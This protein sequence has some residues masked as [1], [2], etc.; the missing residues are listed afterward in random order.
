MPDLRQA[1][2]DFVATSNSGKYA[3][4]E[5]L[6]SKFPELKGYDIQV[7]K[8]FVATSNSGK[9]KTENEL[10]SKFP[11]F[12]LGGAIAPK[13]KDS[14]A[15]I[16]QQEPQAGTTVSPSADGSSV[17]PPISNKKFSLTTQDLNNINKKQPTDMS[18]NPLLPNQKEP[19]KILEKIYKENKALEIERKKYGDIFDNQLNIKPRVDESQYLK[20]RLSSIDTELINKTESF[21]VPKL[22]YQFGDLGFKFEEARAGRDYVKAIAPNG[23]T[24]EISLDNWQDETSKSESEVLKKF[25]KD[26]TPAKGLFVLEKTMRE[27]DKKFNSEKQVDDSVKIISNQVTALNAK[28]KQFLIKKS[29]FEKEIA[30]LS[31]NTNQEKLNELEQQRLSLNEEIKSILQEE[32]TIKQ[33]SKILDAAVGK[34]SIAKS[35]QGSWG[36]A[37]WNSINE[38]FSSISAGTSSL[39]TDIATEIAPA[40]F[41][42]SPKD[43]KNAS[44]DVAKKI[45]VKGPSENQTVEQWKKTLTEDQLDDWEDGIDD[46]IKKDIKSRTLPYIRIGNREILGDAATTKEFSD[47]KQQGFWGGAILGV[48]KSL[49]AMIGGAGPAGWAQRTAQ[50]YTQIADGLAVEMEN[51]P[52]FANIT[53]NEKLA[54]TLPIGITSAVLEAYGL[55]NIMASKGVITSLTMSALGR[56]G[57]GV[58]AKTFRE[59]VENEIKSKLGRGLLI[60]TAAG[61]AE[62]ETGAAQEVTETGFKV[63]YDEIKGKDMF[64]TPD[65]ISDFIR[66]VAVAGAQEAVG[67]F[68][69]GVP[70]GISAAYSKKGFLKMDNL[71]FETFANM[72]NDTKLQSAYIA[73]LK[74]KITQGI[75]TEKEAKERLNNYRNSVGL[76]RRLPDGLTTEQQKEAMNLL[77]EKRD[78]DN[79][80]EGKDPALVVKAK[81]RITEINNELTNLSEK[82]SAEYIIDDK[83][84]TK[85]EFLNELKDKTQEELK[86]MKIVVNN[87]QETMNSINEK[88]KTNAIQ[89]QTADESVLRTEQ[90]ELGLQEVGEGNAQGEV[91]TEQGT[92][93]VTPSETI[94]T[95]QEVVG[96]PDEVSQPIELSVTPEAPVTTTQGIP[97][98]VSQP[99]ELSVTPEV[100]PEQ[101]SEEVNSKILELENQRDAEIEALKAKRQYDE[102]NIKPIREKYEALILDE[103]AK[104]Q[105]PTETTTETAPT[106]KSEQDIANEIN[107]KASEAEVKLRIDVD[108]ESPKLEYDG[109]N[110]SIKKEIERYDRLTRK[111][112]EDG[113]FSN[114]YATGFIVKLIEAGLGKNTRKTANALRKAG[115][116]HTYS[117]EMASGNNFTT[118]INDSSEL[119]AGTYHIL[120]NSEKIEATKIFTKLAKELGIDV[121]SLE[122]EANRPVEKIGVEAKAEVAPAETTEETAPAAET[123]AELDKINSDIEASKERLKKAWD[124]YK[125]MGIA[126]DPKNNL[127]R[128]KEL[129]NS[130]IEYAYNNI[131]LG[132]YNASKFIKDLAEQGFEITKDGAK[133]IIDKATQKIA[134]EE[135]KA[136]IKDLKGQVVDVFKAGIQA[137]KIAET[138]AKEKA[139]DIKIKAKELAKYLDNLKGKGKIT[140]TQAVVIIKRFSEVNVLSEKSVNR[141]IDYATKVLNDA[142]YN[143]KLNEARKTLSSLKKL[144]K[145]AEKNADLR[146]VASQ[147]VKIDPSMVENIDEYNNIAKELKTALDGSKIRRTN[148]N[149]ADTVNIDDV[150]TYVDEIL[151][152]QEIKSRAEKIAELQ[153]LLDVDASQFSAEEIDN[154]FDIYAEEKE[155]DTKKYDSKIVRAALNKAFDIYST[156]IN[157]ML[158]TGVDPFTGE[159]VEF[160]DDQKKIIREF[161]GIDLDTIEDNKEALRIIDSLINFIQNKSTAGMLKPI[162]DY[163]AIVGGNELRRQKIEGK[164]IRK[165]WSPSFGKMLAEQ[166]TSLNLLFEKEFKGFNVAS[167]VRKMMGITDLVNGKSIGQSEANRIVKK[168]VEQF[169]NKTANGEAFNSAYNDIERG[170]FAHVYRNV[171]GTDK[172]RKAVFDK[173]KQEVLDAIDFLE[174]NGNKEEKQLAELYKKAYDKILDKSENIDDVRQKTDAN[175]VDG[176]NYWVNQWAGK[177]DALSDLALNFY[178]KILNRDLGYT[179]DRFKRLQGE[180]KEVDL[181]NDESAF[182][183]NTDGVLYN[184]KSGSLMDKQENRKPPKGMFIDL[185][186]D[187]KNSNSM[188]DAMIDLN[189]A[190]SI[191]KVQSFLNSDNFKKIFKDDADLFKKRISSY[192]R[193]S[194]RKSPYIGSELSGLIQKLDKIATIGVTQALASPTQPFKQTI[195][196][197]ASTLINAGTLGMG[198]AFNP[199]YNNWL[200]KLGYAVS[201]RGMQSSAEIESINRLLEKAANTKKEKVGKFIREANEKMLK[202]TLVKPDVW[203]AR[204]SFKAYYEQYL[205]KEGLYDDV[206]KKQRFGVTEID[207]DIHDPNDD[208]ADYAQ[209]M[210]DRQQNISDHD[211]AGDL[212]TDKNSVTKAFIK[213][214]MAFSSFRMNQGSRLGADLTTLEYWNTST[215]EDKVIALRSIAGYTAEQAVF[216]GLQIT[217]GMMFYFAAKSLMGRGEDDDEDKK[218]KN[219]LIKNSSTGAI[220]DTFSPLPLLDP[221]IQNLAAASVDTFEDIVNIPEEDKIKLF[222]ANKQEAIKAL[223]VY[224]I[225]PERAGQMFDLIK[226]AYGKKYTD[227]YGKQKEISEEDADALKVLIGPYLAASVTGVLAPDVSSLVRK[228]IKISKKGDTNA[229]EER[230][231]KEA[232]QAEQALEDKQEVSLLKEMMDKETNSEKKMIIKKK[233]N[234]LIYETDESKEARKEANKVEKELKEKLLEGY[235]NQSEMKR[236]DPVKWEKNFGEKSDWYKNHKN[237][238]EID[239]QLK[240]EEQK[241]LD[242]EYNYTPKK[243]FGSKTFGTKSSKSK[244]FGSKT[245]GAK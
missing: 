157:Q 204:A 217:F 36:G 197:A 220:T 178:N 33:K 78:L 116:F 153:N 13:K 5:T 46:Y 187:S 243:E 223:G 29:Q 57:T 21:V 139:R 95:A 2:R 90:P 242:K 170:I 222:E 164:G 88:F 119:I 199:S 22:Q 165:I 100:A 141:F 31:S 80:V 91:V 175:N 150:S 67:G 118:L 74:E 133:F 216:R 230:K 111:I 236:Y 18:G 49:P 192:V 132:S 42:L 136:E 114:R 37:I 41:G 79:F 62:F 238:N 201:N 196:V 25:I 168:Y 210:I 184:K 234:E 43:L 145:N 193:L 11:E 177:F 218:F 7:L 209:E 207:Y 144:S 105:A 171:I 125:T 115:I 198:A 130:L 39:V 142:N 104:E 73:S 97:D 149:I 48:A 213:M 206:P 117:R 233:I 99:I 226:L 159:D 56:A 215:K 183:S 167:K 182:I 26:N 229:T 123:K 152:E 108:S 40:G 158:S 122:T 121:A 77:K 212:F 241:Q 70:S 69:L 47:L 225:V 211:L 59:L 154:L 147:F 28:Q 235:D 98:E 221:Y 71:T 15:S 232:K 131:R 169:Y 86:A 109:D 128:D 92:Q 89:E 140:S 1:L 202:L 68:V 156:V 84:Y 181:E 176:V 60:M 113:S 161:M 120:T 219:N 151:A 94:T 188:Y 14:L 146:A 173:R 3:D 237:E 245:F 110:E 103:K 51:N 75:I 239:K 244:G 137:V 107:T 166:F 134:T 6:M 194:R 172:R 179:P 23:K 186:F 138:T 135:A 27:Q 163:Q 101:V 61:V 81:N 55:R 124:K 148:T 200:N 38:G 185:S 93:E 155:F 228:S 162:A 189:T 54:I 160:T 30:N 203:I 32:E 143:T 126:F 17:T 63:L 191:R 53:E 82:P 231:A 58:T 174:E 180:T 10:F 35:K 9:Y 8:D 50:M 83:Q 52:E 64:N 44:I 76:Y 106:V 96:I 16:E 66:N 190:F 34:Y 19:K 12:N 65:S 24:I 87:D 85:D 4:E 208:A 72:A 195:P 112:E 240:K 129:V 205:K 45:G 102:K 227:D 127:A 214:L 20:D 224:G